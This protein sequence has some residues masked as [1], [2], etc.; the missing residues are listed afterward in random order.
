MQ[1]LVHYASLPWTVR[2]GDGISRTG[3]RT[4]ARKPCPGSISQGHLFLFSLLCHLPAKTR[5][6]ALSS[7]SAIPSNPCT[8]LSLL[9]P[10]SHFGQARPLFQNHLQTC[11]AF[12]SNPIQCYTLGYEEN[13]RRVVPALQAL[14]ATQEFYMYHLQS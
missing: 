10:K 6:L 5:D 2:L 13:K 4:R 14:I 8:T 1:G 9:I 11:T 12:R 3:P 7:Y